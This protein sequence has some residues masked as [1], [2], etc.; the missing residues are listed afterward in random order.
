MPLIAPSWAI[1]EAAEANHGCRLL[2]VQLLKEVRERRGPV[3]V[4]ASAFTPRMD[5]NVLA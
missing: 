3:N 5:M 1:K 4:P 2:F